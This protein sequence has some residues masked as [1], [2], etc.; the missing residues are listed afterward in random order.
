MRETALENSICVHGLQQPGVLVIP[1]TRKDKRTCNNPLV[2]EEGGLR[3][4]AGALLEST[5]GQALGTLCVLDKRPRRLNHE[6]KQSLQMLARQVMRL[7]DLQRVNS[8]QQKMMGELNE[9]RQSL[10]KLASTDHL[11]GLNNRRAFSERLQQEHKL[12]KRKGGVTTLLMADIDHFKNINDRFGHAFGD[13]ALAASHR[14]SQMLKESPVRAADAKV[15]MTVSIGVLGL[16]P[17]QD[18]PALMRQLDD[19]LYQAKAA[20]RNTTVFG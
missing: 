19:H 1:D 12:L 10:K 11:T 13:Q 16:D 3:F 7:L 5:D 4:Y 15:R 2:T 20:G 9:A 17:E 14:L 8:A 18:L 6:Q